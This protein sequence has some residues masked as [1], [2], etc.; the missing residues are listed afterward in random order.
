[1]RLSVLPETPVLYSTSFGD[2]EQ[3]NED[4]RRDIPRTGYSERKSNNLIRKLHEMLGIW[5][6]GM[7]RQVLS[8]TLQTDDKAFQS[9]MKMYKSVKVSCN[10]IVDL[11]AD[12]IHPK[13]NVVP[14][15]IGICSELISD[16]RKNIAANHHKIATIIAPILFLLWQNVVLRAQYSQQIFQINFHIPPNNLRLGEH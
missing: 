15:E 9:Q 8:K 6:L 11:L 2:G 3:N 13:D 12:T 14:K 4:Q 1:M 7:T 10:P 16:P 5:P